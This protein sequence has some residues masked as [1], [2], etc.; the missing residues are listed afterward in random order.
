MELGYRG[1]V[2]DPLAKYTIYIHLVQLVKYTIGRLLGD[3]EKCAF[4]Q[5]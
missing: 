3:M 5:L 1:H 2:D 4:K